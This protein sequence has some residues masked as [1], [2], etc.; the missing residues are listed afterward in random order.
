MK[1]CK[2]LYN[3]IRGIK[4]KKK[5]LEQIIEEEDP[6]II[7]ITETKLN[8]DD[9]FEIDGYTTKRVDRT[10]DGGGVLIAYKKCFKKLPL[11]V[12]EEKA[13]EEMLW[14]KIDNGITKLR[15]GIVYMPQEKDVK[16]STIQGIYKKIECEIEKANINGETVILMGDMNCKIGKS[17]IKNN[18]DE[19]S[20]G[21]R[22]LL[23]LCKKMNL[24]VI[25]GMECTTGLWTRKEWKNGKEEKSVLDYILTKKED[26][27]V[28]KKL[29]VDENKRVTPYGFNEEK[30][31]VYTDHC[32]M[33]LETSMKVR[34]EQEKDRKCI[35]EKGYQQLRQKMEEQQ[36]SKI[37]NVENFDK[38]YTEWSNK[39]LE[40][41]EECSTKR[42]KSKGWKVNRKLESFKKKII[43]EL[44]RKD[45]DKETVR[46]LKVEK[47]LIC[48]HIDKEKQ[49]KHHQNVNMEMEKI[50]KE[51]GVDTTA[52]WELKRRVEGGRKEETAHMME[53][54][55]GELVEETEEILQVYQK[56]YQKL[57]TT[58]PGETSIEKEAEE[59]TRIVMEA[60]EILSFGEQPEDIGIETIEKIVAGLKNKK[61]KD[62]S[63][64]KNEY[65][66]A[67]GNEMIKSLKVI[68]GHV[69]RMHEIPS[70]WDEMKIK[71][72]HKKG[73]KV[74]MKNKRGLFITNLISKIYERIV[75]NRNEGR[76][77]L[78]PNQTGGVK[79][80]GGIDNTFTLL[81]VMERNSYLG[82]STVLTLADVEKCFDQ[83]WLD[84]GIKDLW[85]CGMRAR[86]CVALKKLNETAEVT[87]ETPVGRTESVTIKNIVKQGTVYGPPICAAAID[88]IN[89]V[90]YQTVSH[91]GPRVQ[92]KIVAYV[93]DLGSAGSYDTSNTTI[94]NCNVMEEEKKMTMNTDE[95]KSAI[96]VVGKKG[97]AGNVTAVVKK[98]EFKEVQEYKYLGS[99]LDQSG[100]FFRINIDKR[101]QNLSFMI[102]T[103]KRIASPWNMGRFSTSARLKMVETV[104]LKSFLYNV[105]AYPTITKIEM[106]MLE[107][108][109]G[110]MLRDM[111][112][113]PMSTPY[114][115]LLLETGMWTME[116]RIGYRKLMLFHNIMNSDDERLIK[117]IVHEQIRH[118][119]RGTWYHSITVLIEKYRIELSHEELKSTW[120]KHVK[121]RISKVVEEEIR[122]GCEQSSKGRTVARDDFEMKNYLRQLS[123]DEASFILKVRLHMSTLPC[124]YGDKSNCWMCDEKGVKTEHYLR[125]PGTFLMRE[126]MGVREVSLDSQDVDELKTISLFF[127]HLEQRCVLRHSR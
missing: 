37:L 65:I 26:I 47:M 120:K 49:N 81:A 89:E 56:Y 16:V 35:T 114:L 36:I 17:L 25:N 78:S 118:L 5:S 43:K 111:L 107:S 22:V 40:L 42:K 104:L 117:N 58:D 10:S 74:K 101:E 96:L 110:R 95:G 34:N 108:I 115:P 6:T 64:W 45:L 91:Y 82:L 23:S 62:M 124:N 28:I 33:I 50:K 94:Q 70:N 87:I 46:L 7:G 13:E 72:I 71:S 8:K 11:V 44:K 92:I 21:G 119:R 57:L 59:V 100:P 99:W 3:N 80:R 27:E 103:T 75:K 66:K 31:L 113:V 79:N 29:A 85:K 41:V 48:E 106:R 39:V 77:K 60:I 112:N 38:T 93:D 68:M 15:V 1:S 53:N 54:E 52:F 127:K 12:R 97:C 51:G 86:D 14:I 67:G 76:T 122:E 126:C 88:K 116:G 90:G 109:Q 123:V 73:P 20:K 102:S 24:A 18:T 125:C 105:E 121:E 63:C 19:V 30:E 98:G 55:E 9:L 61:A 69:D 4:S 2:I 32:M 83:L 84:D